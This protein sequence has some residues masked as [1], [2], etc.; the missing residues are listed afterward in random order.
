MLIIMAV[1]TEQ[2]PVAAVRRVVVMVMILVMDRELTELFPREFPSAP[3]ADRRVQFE[4]LVPIGLLPEFAIVP[5]FRDD[6]FLLF[7]LWR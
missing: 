2:L 6:P 1:K 5:H 3:R 7:F 4:R